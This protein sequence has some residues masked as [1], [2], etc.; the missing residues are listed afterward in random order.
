MTHK[1]TEP[2][3]SPSGSPSNSHLQHLLADLHLLIYGGVFEELHAEVVLPQG[4][5]TLHTVARAAHKQH[6]HTVLASVGQRTQR[7]RR[8]ELDV[9]RGDPTHAG[10]IVRLCACMWL[11]KHNFPKSKANLCCFFFNGCKLSSDSVGDN[12]AYEYFLWVLE[13]GWAYDWNVVQA[14][15]HSQTRGNYSDTPS[16]QCLSALEKHLLY[17][18]FN[19]P[20]SFCHVA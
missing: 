1:H 16:A 17:C 10:L 6:L 14:A 12:G 11:L 7:N 18:Y 19:R 3:P 20:Q 15:S 13:D 5:V 2:H 9:F 4:R 8:A